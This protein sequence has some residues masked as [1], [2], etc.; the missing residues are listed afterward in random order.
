MPD[1]TPYP[2]INA[3]L[4]LLLDGVRTVLGD[5][6]VGL[7]L[8][9]SVAAGEFDPA[10]SDIDFVV[11][12][13][14]DLPAGLV[15][16]LA[17][18]HQR[19]AA[20]GPRWAVLLEGSYIPLAALRRYDPANAEHPHLSVGGGLRVEHHDAGGVIL[21]HILRE[22]GIVLAGP[23]PSTLIDPVTPADLRR[24][25]VDLFHSWWAPVLDDSTRIHPPAYQAYAVLT[26][27]R[28]LYT[29]HHGAVVPK[30]LAARWAQA[31]LG[32]PWAPLIDRALFWHPDHP[33]DYLPQ[34]LDLIRHT[35]DRI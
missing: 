17:A 30:P 20:A 16:T 12:T 14:G 35:R 28:I 33:F 4:A 23:P 15:P 19:I 2:G 27:C 1:P 18:M 3:L 6:F 21:R 13:T 9:G 29:L 34:T 8:H 7:Y 31:A 24:A 26:M 22:W 11:A 10:R 25:V 32:D 5:R